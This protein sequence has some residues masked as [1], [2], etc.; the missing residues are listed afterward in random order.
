[1][2]AQHAVKHNNETVRNVSKHEWVQ[3]QENEFLYNFFSQLCVL[4]TFCQVTNMSMLKQFK[5]DDA[6]KLD[7]I[8]N[9]KWECKQMKN[10][11]VPMLT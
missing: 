9:A 2:I 5:I 8:V 7:F 6:G 11:I 10:A 4:S 1:M 3:L